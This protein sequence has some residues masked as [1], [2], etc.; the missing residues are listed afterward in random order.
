MSCYRGTAASI[1]ALLVLWAGGDLPGALAQSTASGPANLIVSSDWV[2]QRLGNDNLVLIHVGNRQGYDQEHLPGAHHLS[3]SDISIQQDGLSLQMPT[4]EHLD[5]VFES[6]GVSDNSEIVV[7]FGENWATPTARIVLTLDYLGLGSRTHLLD[8]GMPAWKADGR[9]VT[10]QP[11]TAKRGN[12]TP[13]PRTDVI[14]TADWLNANRE[15]PGIAVLDARTPD[16]YSGMRGG[17]GMPRAGHVA[18]ANNIPF[19]SLLEDESLKFKDEATLRAMFSAAGAEPGETVVTYCHIG[20]QASLLYLAA[21]RLGYEARMYDGS[22]QEW[23]NRPDLPIESPATQALPKLVATAELSEMLAKGGVTVVD[24]RSNLFTYLE[25]HIPGAAYL[26]YETLR[27][28]QSGVPADLLPAE[29]YAALFSQLGIRKDRPVV[30]YSAGDSQN[31][32]ATFLV[33]ILNGF[34]H[35]STYLLDGGYAK[36][37]AEGRATS[38][39]YP[40][41]EA[42]E[43]PAEPFQPQ[44]ARLGMVR[45]TVENADRPGGT[46]MVLV[47][48]RPVEQYEG[49]S[50]SQ[51]RRGHIPGAINHVWSSDLVTQGST[52]VWKSVDELRA[53][54]VAQGITPDKHVILYCNTG[55]EASHVHFALRN[56]LNYPNVDVYVPSWT[57][58]SALKDLPIASAKN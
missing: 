17:H 44:L 31:F 37:E 13:R 9:E 58:W 12:L 22:F 19:N 51:M 26:H 7:Y 49:R 38:R 33:W 15:K 21:R 5:S 45:W 39:D 34:G 42:S 48:V 53:A 40:T 27:A 6:I 25:G 54:Y 18:G 28:T 1:V 29:S 4:V 46:G 14:A 23:S 57:E 24:L 50:G 47:D 3:L 8:G 2:A 10:G 43:F 55:T 32:N 30:I 56:L 36:W 11:P 16:F 35:P 52:K 20:Q 41:I